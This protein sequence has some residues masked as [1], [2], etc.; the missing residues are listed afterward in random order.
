VSLGSKLKC[1]CLKETGEER[2]FDV[3]DEFKK[4]LSK[5]YPGIL[6]I[7]VPLRNKRIKK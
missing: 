7:N 1:I 6:D 3:I 5:K 2:V 4:T